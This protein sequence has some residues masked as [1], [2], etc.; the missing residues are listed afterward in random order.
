V[1]KGDIMDKNKLNALI[2]EK[3]KEQTKLREE[4]CNLENRY[5]E[6]YKKEE[7]KEKYL[8]KYF[9]YPNNCYGCAETE[10]DY[11]NVYYFV[12]NINNACGID[13]IVFSEDCYKQIEIKKESLLEYN[14]KNLIEITFEEFL[15]SINIIVGDSIGYKNNTI[16]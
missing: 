6:L 2:E 7:L 8:F 5:A 16:K 1:K 11:W 12:E 3:Q 10:D 4:I 9:M 14:F 15:K 13:C